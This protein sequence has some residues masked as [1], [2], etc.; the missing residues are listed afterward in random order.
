MQTIAFPCLASPKLL[1]LAGPGVLFD[2]TGPFGHNNIWRFRDE[3][4]TFEGMTI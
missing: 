1:D 3:A 4:F 2:L